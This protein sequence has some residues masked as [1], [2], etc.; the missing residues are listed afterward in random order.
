MEQL[1]KEIRYAARRLARSPAFTIAS[2]LTLALAIGANAA[3]FA[4]VERVVINPLPYP[5]SD[6]L[7]DVDHGA[8]AFKLQSGMKM[9]SGMY[10]M[11]QERARSLQSIALYLSTDRTLVG[12]GEPERLRV[13]AATPSL[14]AVLRVAPAVGRWFTDDEGKPGGRAVAVLSH[15]LWTRRF[16]GN[17][18][19]VGRTIVLDGQSQ[20]VIG[21][22]PPAFAFPEFRTDVWVPEQLSVTMGFGL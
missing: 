6:R 20:E 13:T 11:Y 16:G 2:V 22:M 7:I 10:F 3:I 5:G 8:D 18:G 1:Q 17:P 4:V 15:S 9:T 19:I 12:D 21:V 14:G